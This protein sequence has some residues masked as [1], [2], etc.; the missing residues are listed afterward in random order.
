MEVESLANK[1]FGY[2]DRDMDFI[3]TKKEVA[4]IKNMAWRTEW[5]KIFKI[6]PVPMKEMYNG[7][8]PDAGILFQDFL[9]FSLGNGIKILY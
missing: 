3:L 2:A 8:G 4:D 9:E 5:D 7:S 6:L 1:F